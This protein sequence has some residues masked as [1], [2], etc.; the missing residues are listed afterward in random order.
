MPSSIK[1]A[2]SEAKN[3]KL[4]NLLDSSFPAPGTANPN[5]MG[6]QSISP[7]K[8]SNYTGSIQGGGGSLSDSMEM[9]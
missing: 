9:Q 3:K 8:E 1:E 6:S 2:M 7:N 4:K 5:Y